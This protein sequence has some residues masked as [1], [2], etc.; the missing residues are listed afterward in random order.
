[1]LLGQC[2]GE[3]FEGPV[4][5]VLYRRLETRQGVRYLHHDDS[6]PEEEQRERLTELFRALEGKGL[7]VKYADRSTGA[8]FPCLEVALDEEYHYSVMTTIAKG[9]Y[10]HGEEAVRPIVKRLGLRI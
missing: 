7:P 4:L 3:L 8:H 6:I 2:D 10:E 1:M 5:D 9:V